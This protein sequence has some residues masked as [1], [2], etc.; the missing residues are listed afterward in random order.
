MKYISL[1]LLITW[2]CWSLHANGNLKPNENPL[3]WILSIL[4][5]VYSIINIVALYVEKRN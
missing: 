4:S 2:S 5:I 1:I 3:L